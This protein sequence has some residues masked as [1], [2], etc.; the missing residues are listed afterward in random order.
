MNPNIWREAPLSAGVEH[1]PLSGVAADE[2]G[3]QQQENL[4][5]AALRKGVDVWKSSPD[6]LVGRGQHY[7][8]WVEGESEHSQIC[9][10]T[11]PR[12]MSEVESV[13]A[14][15][16]DG[17]VAID[18]D[19]STVGLVDGYDRPEVHQLEAGEVVE[20][21]ESSELVGVGVT[22]VVAVSQTYG[23]VEYVGGSVGVVEAST[24]VVSE[25]HEADPSVRKCIGSEMA[26]EVL[27]VEVLEGGFTSDEGCALRL[28][29]GS[30]THYFVV[31]LPENRD[32]W[33]YALATIVSSARG[34][35]Y[36][37]E[38]S[39][40]SEEK[41]ATVALLEVPDTVGVQVEN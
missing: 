2:E 24:V 40:F 29:L 33:A 1:V 18:I 28:V 35:E 8:L 17:E 21:H 37:V 5:I 25:E 27:A 32:R 15:S 39:T 19:G 12:T 14:V 20:Q 26:R 11:A 23:S 30:N 41:D 36:N 22:S 4:S 7:L 34:I 16:L 3:Y 38:T 13:P 6:R 9:W 10:G 31:D